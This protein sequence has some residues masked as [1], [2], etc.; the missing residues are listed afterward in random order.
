[1]IQLGT[2]LFLIHSRYTCLCPYLPVDL[3]VIVYCI[4]PFIHRCLPSRYI[5]LQTLYPVLGR[6]LSFPPQ[7]AE[8]THCELGRTQGIPVRSASHGC[9]GSVAASKIYLHINLY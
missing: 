6:L 7:L 1:M 3:Q 9:S 5:T 2:T 4:V 8:R